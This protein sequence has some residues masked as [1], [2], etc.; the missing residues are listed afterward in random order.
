MKRSDKRYCNNLF[1]VTLLQ[2]TLEILCMFMDTLLRSA[3]NSNQEGF[4]NFLCV[5]SVLYRLYLNFQNVPE[6]NFERI[7]VR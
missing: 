7:D 2:E 1:I 3:W 5:L 4:E 6:K